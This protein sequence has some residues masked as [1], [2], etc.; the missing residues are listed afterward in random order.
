MRRD[1]LK[2]RNHITHVQCRRLI[3][4][5]S[6]LTCG[7]IALGIT[8][9]N[10]QVLGYER[11]RDNSEELTEFTEVSPPMRGDIF[12]RRGN[13]MA[14]SIR[15]KTVCADP[16]VIGGYNR[17]VARA[18]A[19]LLGYQVDKL[20]DKIKVRTRLVDG[21]V[22]TNQY[23]VLKHNVELDDWKRVDKVMSELDLGF[24]T[25]GLP[26]KE[27]VFIDRLKKM[28]IFADRIERQRR[29]Y[30]N[31]KLASHLL[32]FVRIEERDVNGRRVVDMVGVN[33]I[34]RS[35]DPWL[36]GASG[37]RETLLRSGRSEIFTFRTGDLRARDGFDIVLT[38]D[39]RIQQITEEA[40]EGLVAKHNPKSASAIVIEPRT[41]RLLAMATLPNYDPN[42]PGE[43]PT[44]WRRNRVISDI[45]EP[46][47]T[48]KVITVSAAINEGLVSLADKF[49]CEDGRFFF[50]GRTLRDHH[51]YGTLS[52]KE[53]LAKSS[54]IGAAKIGIRMGA[55]TLYR[56][57]R[58]FGFGEKTGIPL[59]GEVSGITHPV[60]KWSGISISR[61]P[62]GQGVAVT[63]LQMTMSAC[64]VANN[65]VLM[66]PML[67]DKILGGNGEVI[68]GYHP[69]PVRRVIGEGAAARVIEA[70]KMVAT[71]NGTAPAAALEHYSVAGKTGTAQKPGRGGYLPGKYFASFIGFFPADNPEVCIAVFVDEPHNGYYGS[72][73]AAPFFNEIAGKTAA[74]LCVPP[75][76]RDDESVRTRWVRSGVDGGAG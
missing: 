52:V 15:V 1:E 16:S 2:T 17:E 54:N 21:E 58:R 35:F 40:L 3:V 43:Y 34:E 38:I 76:P 14:T 69:Q 36:T 60:D 10:L 61:I 30:P 75:E 72:I 8:I 63:P 11:Y 57:I 37:W 27:R 32:G 70:M 29:I 59:P 31:A 18:V 12:D 19:P 55:E 33:G 66:R 23:V 25:S 42:S 74:Y 65:G 41:G 62:I 53:V 7:F 13:L 5:A 26:Y 24:D 22:V 49:F 50:M 48:F 6:V 71:T 9:Y 56:Y 39:A 51:S 73:A 68:T 45:A 47:S 64:A 28:G 44:A 67:V 20:A 4:I 46:G